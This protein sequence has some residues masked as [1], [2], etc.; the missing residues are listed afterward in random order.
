LIFCVPFSS[1]KKGHHDWIKPKIKKTSSVN[2]VEIRLTE[3][4]WNHIRRRHPEMENHQVDILK[5]VEHPD[6]IQEGDHQALMAVRHYS[7]TALTSKYL[8]VVYREMNDDDGFVVTAY[9]TSSLSRRR[10]VIWKR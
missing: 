2:G 10:P 7:E 6:L 5:T 1:R 9:L 3:E 8:V 4:R